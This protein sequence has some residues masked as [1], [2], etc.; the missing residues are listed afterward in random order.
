MEVSLLL[1]VGVRKA[2]VVVVTKG[3]KVKTLRNFI[4]GDVK[5]NTK[6]KS[7]F[8]KNA[9]SIAIVHKAIGKSMCG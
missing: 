4:V 8:L 1:F 3:A 2:H 9:S 5:E 7:N 6:V